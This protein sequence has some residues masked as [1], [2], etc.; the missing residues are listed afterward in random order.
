MKYIIKIFLSLLYISSP[1]FAQTTN[2]SEILSR[3][4]SRIKT[5]TNP[6]TEIQ[7]KFDEFDFYREYG[8]SKIQL[9]LK[10]N[11]QTV[12]LMTSILLSQ[13]P[14]VAEINSNNLLS[15]LYQQY[16]ETTKFDPVRYFLGMAQMGAVGYL[17]YKHIKKYGLF[18]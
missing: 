13:T 4:S 17:A 1:V 5:K 16:I 3:D 12:W 10:D 9:S 6:L 18:K 14:N 15:P 8:K 11:P 2:S 7:L